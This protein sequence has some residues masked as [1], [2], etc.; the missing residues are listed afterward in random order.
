MWNLILKQ[1]AKRLFP[2][3]PFESLSRAQLQ[4]I[5]SE[6][7][8]IMN[9]T[10]GQTAEVV[11][12]PQ[13][14]IRSLPTEQTI[15]QPVRRGEIFEV[16][17]DDAYRGLQ[18][19]T[20]R[21]LIANTD[22]DVKAFGKRIIENKQDVKFEKLTKDQR[23]GILDM[24][25]DRIKMGNRKFMEKYDPMFPPE[26]FASGGIARVGFAGGLLAKL[27]KGVK[28][29]QH[30]AI[31]RKLRK[32]YIETGMDKFKAYNKAMDDASDVVNQKKLEIV[33]NKMNKVNV[34][35]DD[36]VD[37]IDEHIRL[38]DRETYKDIKRWK[39]TRPD[40]ADKTRALY[41][42]DWAKTRYGEDYQGVLNKRQA[43][44]LKEQSDEINRMYPDKSDTDILVDEIDEM[45]KANIDEIIE[46]RKKNA[47]GGIARVGM[48]GGG[49]IVKGGN[50]LIK[51]LLDTRQKI[52]TMNMS[53]GQLKYYLNQIDDQIK[54]IKAGGAIP[55][56]V[57]QT[58]RKDPKFRSVSQTRSTDPDLR[59]MEEVLLEYGEKHASGG[60]AGELHLHRPGYFLGGVSN[61]YKLLKGG[62]N[63]YRGTS[64]KGGIGGHFV[65]EGKEFLKGKYY[66]TDKK[67]AE[68]YAELGKGILGIKKLTL[69]KKELAK[70][71]RI[72]QKFHEEI[73]L[74]KKLAK[75]AEIDI[76]GSIKVNM[77]KIIKDIREG[78]AEG[79]IAG[80]LH[81]NRPGYSNGK[82]VKSPI[83]SLYE[84]EDTHGIAGGKVIDFE[85]H[86]PENIEP[87]KTKEE[88]V[89][90]FVELPEK[91]QDI[92][93]E[94]LA[95]QQ[96]KWKR[97]DYKAWDKYQ[98]LYDD[99]TS[100]EKEAIRLEMREEDFAR[101]EKEL[102]GK[103]FEKKKERIHTPI[104]GKRE[105]E[106]AAGIDILKIA[107]EMKVNYPD[108]EVTSLG[109]LKKLIQ[110]STIT[111]T[112]SAGDKLKFTNMI[113]DAE[114]NM[115]I[116]SS[117]RLGDIKYL[118]DSGMGQLSTEQELGPV[119]LKS[120]LTFKD[121]KLQEGAKT[122]FTVPLEFSKQLFAKYDDLKLATDFSEA[123]KG[124]FT[125]SPLDVTAQ[126]SSDNL[127]NIYAD[128]GVNLKHGDLTY[129]LTS[130][131]SA[132]D[133]KDLG[134]NIG[135]NKD[136]ETGLGTG[137]LTP[138]F[139]YN[140]LEPD[141]SKLDIGYQH[142]FDK[143]IP[144][145]GDGTLKIGGELDK[146]GQNFGITFKKKFAKGG[147]AKILGV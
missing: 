99:L 53:P 10:K 131:Y 146:S 94:D 11:G 54:N 31:E 68:M 25:D 51:S 27:Y 13:K 2:R 41:F 125:Y 36:Y 16:L 96:S 129:G 40:L 42:P 91:L 24:I 33:E 110:D 28:G 84:L 50:W 58:I 55:E 87:Q 37:L 35:S 59:E 140:I 6:T 76:P 118:V 39:N 32:Q 34:N 128:L 102:P 62:K 21:R 63:V 82:T 133:Q 97:K 121:G 117:T 124:D 60:I 75:E 92:K 5:T 119:Q 61:F 12:L 3:T 80:E 135:L 29:L 132:D 9:R 116:T 105:K 79:G 57:I 48:F 90:E 145:V 93:D 64:T 126:I 74:P 88:Q 70:A 19:D 49:P 81:L 136:F 71:K 114:N 147:L 100:D 112:F 20:F 7:T 142:E 109:E 26:D 8:K 106:L 22:D 69:S 130:K 67:L 95:E 86:I 66:T 45:N 89:K 38:T 17:D 30:G 77:K 111:Q 103:I 43:S 1:V 108:R 46:G 138:S 141:K 127:E 73:I 139:S 4:Q 85:Q 98:K 14:G 83:V 72:G 122:T 23:K 115:Q 47:S 104:M 120:N 56:E 137:V 18:A 134:L 144:Y 78:N 107:S 143:T 65:P 101:F 15:E 113:N 123:G 52:K 44:A